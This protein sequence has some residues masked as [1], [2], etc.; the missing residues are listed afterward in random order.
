MSKWSKTIDLCSLHRLHFLQCFLV[1]NQTIRRG[2]LRDHNRSQLHQMRTNHGR[3]AT[4]R[5]FDLA[6]FQIV[7]VVSTLVNDIG[8]IRLG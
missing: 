2:G 4:I 1:I 5:N 3:N 8:L 7:H 6:Y